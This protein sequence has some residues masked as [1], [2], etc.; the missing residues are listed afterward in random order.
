MVNEIRWVTPRTRRTW[1]GLVRCLVLLVSRFE[2]VRAR[3]FAPLEN[4]GLQDDVI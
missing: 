1:P 4:A 2:I 3:S